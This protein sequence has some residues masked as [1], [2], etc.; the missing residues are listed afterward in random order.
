MRCFILITLALLSSSVFSKVTTFSNQTVLVQAL[1]D[2]DEEMIYEGQ[3]RGLNLVNANIAQETVNLGKNVLQLFTLT[4]EYSGSKQCEVNVV[5]EN[6]TK[7]LHSRPVVIGSV[8]E[9]RFKEI[10]CQ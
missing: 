10:N 2:L 3:L 8:L 4:L 7:K 9:R 1:S 6:R 5:Y